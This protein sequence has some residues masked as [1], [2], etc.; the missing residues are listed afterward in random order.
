MPAS[1]YRSFSFARWISILPSFN[2]SLGFLLFYLH[3]RYAYDKFS[4]S[5]TS[6]F[7]HFL[8]SC[9]SSYWFYLVSFVSRK[10]CRLQF[11]SGY[12]NA[13]WIF[14]GHFLFFFFFF[15]V[16]VL[17]L[18]HIFHTLNIYS[19]FSVFSPSPWFS[20]VHY[21]INFGP[22]GFHISWFLSLSLSLILLVI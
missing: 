11:V 8:R 4:I 19:S 1:I 9:F 14:I 20:F 13:R 22:F 5:L 17:S 7:S 12:N 15:N 2:L 10:L 18:D 16:S 3:V 21:V 6:S